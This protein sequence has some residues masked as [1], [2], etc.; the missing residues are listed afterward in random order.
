M[1][2]LPVPIYLFLFAFAFRL[3]VRMRS[4][5]I[6]SSESSFERLRTKAFAS[7]FLRRV[8]LRYKLTIDTLIFALFIDVMEISEH[9]D[10]GKMGASIIYNTFTS[11]L[12]DVF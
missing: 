8:Y 10:R 2:S 3:S 12:D 11:V 7:K 4:T 1:P 6:K 9:L 5:S